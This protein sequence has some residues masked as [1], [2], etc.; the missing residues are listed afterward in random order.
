MTRAP[1]LALAVVTLA[2]TAAR[3]D[4]P[5]G[6]ES[7]RLVEGTNR[8]AGAIALE[9]PDPDSPDALLWRVVLVAGQTEIAGTITSVAPGTRPRLLVLRVGE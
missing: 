8:L 3:A 6:L 7:I 2:M 9:D 1:A 5:G 4:D